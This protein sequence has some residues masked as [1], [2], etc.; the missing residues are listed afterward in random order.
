MEKIRRPQGAALWLTYQ[1]QILHSQSDCFLQGHGRVE[2]VRA[3]GVIQL[4]FGMM[5]CRLFTATPVRYRLGLWTMKWVENW[6]D[7][8][9]QKV[10]MAAWG[11]AGGWLLVLCLRD[12]LWDQYCLKP[13]SM[14]SMM[15]WTTLYD[16]LDRTPNGEQQSTCWKAGLLFIKQYSLEKLADGKLMTFVKWKPVQS[17]TSVMDCSR[18]GC[19]HTAEGS[20]AEKAL[21]EHGVIRRQECT[22]TT[23]QPPHARLHQQGARVRD[24]DGLVNTCKP[25]LSVPSWGLGSWCTTSPDIQEEDQWR[26]PVMVV[27]GERGVQREVD[28]FSLG[29]RRKRGE[30]T[31]ACNCLV[32]SYRE[33]GTRLCLVGQSNRMW[34]NRHMLEYGKHPLGFRK[35]IY[36]M[37]MVKYYNKTWCDPWRRSDLRWPW[38]HSNLKLLEQPDLTRPASSRDLK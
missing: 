35:S 1:R 25:A 28:W 4:D 8:Q 23:K 33:E 36:S 30:L 24:P 17:W 20:S 19:S 22:N 27:F 34:G 11:P 38:R 10:V 31:A 29:K 2:K 18:T 16:S 7:F 21:V 12:W 32:G 26:A 9:V 15:G 6:L 5:S 37:R 3:A 14:T 13:S